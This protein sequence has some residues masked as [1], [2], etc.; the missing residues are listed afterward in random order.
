[1]GCGAPV[2]TS[3]VTSLPEVCG[4]AAL[5]VD[6]QSTEDIAAKIIELY[7]DEALQTRFSAL[8]LQRA[9]RFRSI[10]LGAVTVAAYEEAARGKVFK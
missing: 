9:E 10:D 1:M 7:R 8:G 2:I 3:N 6:P 5:Y 4:D